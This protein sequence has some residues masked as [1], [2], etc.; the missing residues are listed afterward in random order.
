MNKNTENTLCYNCGEKISIGDKFCSQCG[1]PVK[2]K[3]IDSSFSKNE[4]NESKKSRQKNNASKNE[5]GVKKI[6]SVKIFYFSFI[7]IL[8]GFLIAYSSGIFDSA[9]ISSVK[10]NINDTQHSGVDLKYLDRINQLE[11]ELKTNPDKN[12]LLELAHLLNDS[13]F[14]ERAIEKYLTYLKTNPKDADVLVDLG[15]CYY[16]L[17]K[18]DVALNYMKE[19]L[20]Y[21][22]NH[23][24]AHL[25]IGIVSLA[26]NQHDEAINWWK[27]AVEINPR[28]EIGKRAQELINSH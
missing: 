18:N 26:S 10:Q 28:N 19:A 14:K 23:Q 25:N 3:N 2:S 8:I 21:Q 27:K 17:G 6:S 4:K 16:E 13:G 15:V 5:S 12:K 1:V 24:I 22:P 20:K 11:E 7:L 9:P